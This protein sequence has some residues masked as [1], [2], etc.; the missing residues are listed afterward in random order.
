MN[1]DMNCLE[2]KF[3]DC[4]N[5]DITDKEKNNIEDS[6]FKVRYENSV[7]KGWAKVFRYQH[8]EHGKKKIEEYRKTSEVY[9]ATQHRYAVS[10][11]GRERQRRYYQRHKEEICAK[12]REERRLRKEQKEKCKS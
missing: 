12:K 3:K 5:D 10:E 6:D 7:K 1:C 9:K 8:S 2:C 11:K 4:I